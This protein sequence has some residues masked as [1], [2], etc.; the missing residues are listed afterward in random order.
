MKS[1]IVLIV[2]LIGLSLFWVAIEWKHD[3]V[4][5]V[6]D[7]Q[8][9]TIKTSSTI[10]MPAQSVVAGNKMPEKAFVE[11][12]TMPPG[13]DRLAR[14]MEQ[15]IETMS[16]ATAKPLAPVA[17][18]FVT[19]K[20]AEKWNAFAIFL[21]DVK[22]T[23]VEGEIAERSELPSPEKSDYPDCRFTAHFIGHAIKEGD[24]CPKEISLI[25]EGFENFKILETN[26]LKPGDKVECSIIPFRDIPDENQTTQQ[27]DD[28]ELFLLDNYYVVSIERIRNYS[29]PNGSMPSSG[30][31]FSEGNEEYVSIFERHINPPIPDTVKNAQSSAIQDDLRKMDRILTGFDEGNI[32]IINERFAEA[33]KKEKEK[34]AKGYNRNQKTVWRNIDNSFWALPEDF[35]LLSKPS[36]MSFNMLSCFESLKRACEENGVQLIVSLVPNYYD[37]SARV[38][39]KDF[40]DIPDIQTATYVKQLSEIGIESIYASDIIIQNYNRFPFAFFFPTNNHPGDTTQDV[41]SDIIVERLRRYNIPKN[42]DPELFEAKME[43]TRTY[44][45]PKPFFPKNCDIGYNAEGSIYECKHIY[46]D[47]MPI[48]KGDQ[49]SPIIIIGNSFI[50]TPMNGTP[51]LSLPSL[52]MYKTL[53]SVYWRMMNSYG[54]F[55]DIPLRILLNPASFF[56]KKKV[57]IM[58]VGTD[59]ITAVSKNDSM[60]NIAMLDNDRLLLKDKKLKTHFLLSSNTQEEIITDKNLW[61]PIAGVEKTVLEIGENGV[62]TYTFHLDHAMDSQNGIDFSKPILCVV[63]STCLPDTNCKLTINEISNSINSPNRTTLLRFYNLSF[64]LPAGTRKITIRVEGKPGLVLAVKDI[65]I[66]Q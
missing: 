46:Y 56:E 55:S 38:I 31:L 47:G 1:I 25:I 4:P 5:A 39:N 7:K 23:V 27:A 30:I 58:Q 57:L 16:I 2:I 51:D 21:A 41:L 60:L 13:K 26:N 18:P 37:I 66:W 10:L 6:Q 42:L 12:V 63:P 32:D 33:W 64:E 14:E 22:K 35:T 61:G 36:L 29:E 40:R 28:L 43:N 20:D 34:D 9:G 59:H 50:K 3:D 44:T 48:K 53:S 15:E 17:V 45:L 52:I 54:P 11:N 62:L 24:S 8:Q 19:E 65:Q 49:N